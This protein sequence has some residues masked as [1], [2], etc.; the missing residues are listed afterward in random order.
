MCKSMYLIVS[1]CLF[2]LA[3]RAEPA[4]S[5]TLPLEE[6]L[7]VLLVVTAGMAAVIL[8]ARLLASQAV[9]TLDEW[10]DKARQIAQHEHGRVQKI[11]HDDPPASS[12]APPSGRSS[13]RSS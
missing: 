2:P 9:R 6:V 5:A 10:K 8:L 12:I 7:P 13:R 11:L 1:I 4:P 3:V